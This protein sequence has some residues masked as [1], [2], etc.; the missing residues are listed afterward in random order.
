MSEKKNQAKILKNILRKLSEGAAIEDVTEEFRAA[1]EGVDAR[2]IAAAEAELIKAGMPVEELQNLCN[3]HASVVE[4]T[5]NV[6][7]VDP[8][9]GHP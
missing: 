7:S 2:E 1:F 5:V 6:I 9:I 4:G 3:V 8:V